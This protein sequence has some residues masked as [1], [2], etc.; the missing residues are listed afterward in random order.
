MTRSIKRKSLITL[1]A[2]GLAVFFFA[3]IAAADTNYIYQDPT[4]GWY[5]TEDPLN[6]MHSR[7]NHATSKMTKP[8]ENTPMDAGQ[9]TTSSW[10]ETED[11]LPNFESEPS[12]TLVKTTQTRPQKNVFEGVVQY[13]WYET[14]DALPKI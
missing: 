8:Y 4:S 10:Y 3:N 14:E 5:E 1:T 11:S 6:G 7:D 12:Q 2:W 13:S 9:A